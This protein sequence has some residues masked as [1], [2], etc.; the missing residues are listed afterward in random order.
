MEK[1]G[2]FAIANYLYQEGEKFVTRFDANT[3][4]SLTKAMN[5]HDLGRDRGDNHS[6]LASIQQPTLVISTPTDLLYGLTEQEELARFIPNAKFAKLNSIHGHDAF[7]I[8]LKE[9]NNLI[10]KG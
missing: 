7:L 1:F 9:I 6:V 3:Y 4:I 2:D 10:L 8:A 5:S